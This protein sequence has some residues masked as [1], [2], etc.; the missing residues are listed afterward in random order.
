MLTT[1]TFW[2][3]VRL[4]PLVKLELLTW[5]VPPVQVMTRTSPA[6]SVAPDK[7]ATPLRLTVTVVPAAWVMLRVYAR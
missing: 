3:T 5:R 4:L 2:L 6:Y 1:V 7:R